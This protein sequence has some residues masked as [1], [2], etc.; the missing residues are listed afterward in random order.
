MWP[1]MPTGRSEFTDPGY[2]IL[3]NYE[4]HK[5]EF[6]VPRNVYRLDAH[7]GEA[8]AVLEGFGRAQWSLLLAGLG[9]AL[10]GRYRR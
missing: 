9:Q 10:C 4:G 3:M 7:S 6:E 8:T 2:G 5:A 1:F